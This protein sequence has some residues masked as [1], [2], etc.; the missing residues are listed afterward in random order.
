MTFRKDP[1]DFRIALKEVIFEETGARRPDSYTLKFGCTLLDF[2]NSRFGE[3]D[4]LTLLRCGETATRDF[5]AATSRLLIYSDFL[6][7]ALERSTFA[8]DDD[9]LDAAWHTFLALHRLA[10]Q[11]GCDRL[12]GWGIAALE[13]ELANA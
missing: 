12:V 9:R 4:L 6:A 10:G 1:A 8:E 3:E 11:E 13:R 5:N 2:L 7:R